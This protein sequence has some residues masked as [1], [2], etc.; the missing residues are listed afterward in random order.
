MPKRIRKLVYTDKFS[1]FIRYFAVFT[2]IFG[3]MT[4]I[5]FQLMRS[6]MYQ[7]SD[8]TLKRI[9]EE[10]AMA[11]GFAIARTYEP[12]SVFI[13]Q[14]SPTSEETTSSSSDSMPVPKDQKNTR[15]GDQLRLG[16]NTHVLLYSKSGEMV[17]PDT[18]TG[19]ADLLLDKEKLGEI[20]EATVESSFGMSEDYRYVTIEL[21]TDELGYYSSYDIKYAT[22]LVNVSQIKSSIETYESTVAIVMVSAWL[23]SIL[24]SIYLSNLSMRPILISYQKQKDFVE[25]ASHELRTPLA[26]LQNRLESLFRHPEATILESSESIGSSLEEV[27]NMRLLTTNLLNLARRDDG[28]KVDMIDVQ[29]NYFDEI[30]ANYLMIAEENGKTLTVNN[31]IHQPI[32]TDKVLIK[33]LLT[34]LFDNAMKYTDDDGRIQITANIKDKSV[35]FTV[36]DNGLGISDADKKKIFDRFYRVDKART[37]QKGGFG[38]GLSLAQQIIKTLGGKISVRDN[39]PKGTIFEVGL[40]K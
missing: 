5:I 39:Q 18:F 11:V 3:L 35:Y 10:P 28:L 22:I 24:A 15:D 1:F 31:L 2:L 14:D 12:N 36:T 20:K 4:A 26:V 23:I 33:Q 8:N 21:A 40:P 6:T 25:N 38:L 29:P 13:L 34:I 30:F 7:N 37:R 9:K 32:R 27:R 16:V 19:L 17:N